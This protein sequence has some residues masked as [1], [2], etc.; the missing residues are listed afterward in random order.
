M[1]IACSKN[2]SHEISSKHKIPYRNENK[3]Q[4]KKY[5]LY[6]TPALDTAV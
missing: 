3:I 1:D 4:S 5:N 2:K 6:T